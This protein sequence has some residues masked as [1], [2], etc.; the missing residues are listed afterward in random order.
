MSQT[1]AVS[2]QS[3]TIGDT[4]ITGGDV[5]VCKSFD[6]MGSSDAILHGIYGYGFEKPSK[7]QQIGNVIRVGM[8]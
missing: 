2:S 8:E 3:K 4:I 5:R 1:T 7:I 6:E